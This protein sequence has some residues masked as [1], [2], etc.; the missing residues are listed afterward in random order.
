M[1]RIKDEQIAMAVVVQ[2]MVDAVCAGVMFTRSP[3]TGD[4]SVIVIE[5]SWGLGASLV[6]GEVTPDRFVVNKVTSEIVTRNIS[7]KTLEHVADPSGT[8][9]R[10]QPVDEARR[11]VPC[12]TDNEIRDLWQTAKTVEQHYGTPQDIEWA[13]CSHPDSS[14]RIAYLLQSRPETVWSGREKEPAARPAAK[15]FDHV[16]NLLSTRS[17]RP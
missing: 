13:L 5:G 16:L 2:E 17:K 12:L 14:E 11:R 9:V 10:E 7:D 15:D 6:S 4:K 3:T 1:R 8:G